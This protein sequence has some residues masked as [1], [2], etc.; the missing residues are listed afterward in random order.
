MDRYKFLSHLFSS[1]KSKYFENREKIYEYQRL[2]PGERERE[3]ERE[4][5]KKDK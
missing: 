4:R 3:R 5:E 1:L 2:R